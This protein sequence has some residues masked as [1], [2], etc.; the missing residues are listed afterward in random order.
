MIADVLFSKSCLPKETTLDP[1]NAAGFRIPIAYLKNKIKIKKELSCD[2]EL[3][4][5]ENPL[6]PALF[7]A[8]D[9]IKKLSLQQHSTWYT[10]DK[11]YLR[12]TQCILKGDLPVPPNHGLMYAFR[13][14]VIDPD[15]FLEKYNYIEWDKLQFMN[16]NTHAMQWL[17]IY[18]IC[19]PIISLALP[20]FM[21]MIPFFLI[22][23][24]NS[25]ISWETYYQH[26]K[27]VLRNH[28][29]GQLFY[30]GSAGWDKRIMMCISIIF[31]FVQVY[32]NCTSCIKFVKNMTTIHNH[33]FI[34]KEY[35]SESIQAMNF[36]SNTWSKFKT[37]TPFLTKCDE[38]RK[39]AIY[40][41]DELQSIS[42]LRPSVS[43]IGEIG[44][45]MRINY[46]IH[47]DTTWKNI[48]EYCVQFNSYILSM[49]SLKSKIG[50]DI[51]Y[52]KF[53]KSTM[54]KGLKYPHISSNKAVLNDIHLD[55]NILIT[56]PNAAGKTTILK[57]TMINIILCQQFGCGYFNS[58]KIQPY[59]ILSSYINIP[60]TSGRD[61]L[62]QA[63]ASRC[64][65]IL[66][67]LTNKKRHL[68]IFDELFSGTNPYE[69]IGAATAYLKYI[70]THDHV[71][72]ILTTHFLDLCRILDKTSKVSN[73]QMQV[74][75]SETGFVYSYK[76]I[77]GISTVKGGIKVLTDLGYPSSIIEE[78]NMIMS[79]LKI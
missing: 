12:D 32:F 17:S 61:S 4:S 37:Y 58:A 2:L 70:N 46:M 77:E 28:S 76:M 21:L 65:S 25:A 50:V 38:V 18:N 14:E 3:C 35:V 44:R 47:M 60:D 29:L 30:I 13:K 49:R 20:I 27:I 26:L 52:C 78:S 73:M 62:F 9:D 1:L 64:K 24:Q 74:N 23:I 72:F 79:K 36:I 6:Y 15:A 69:A 16:K 63:E 22:R 43:K 31:Y 71:T 19:S 41:N 48:I 55:K 57:A 34:V 67:E 8:D 75:H 56:G 59:D 53:T 42:R 7:C 45:A 11:K 33:I 51:N 66:D 68:C 40:I 39:Q 10:T 54:L 5:G